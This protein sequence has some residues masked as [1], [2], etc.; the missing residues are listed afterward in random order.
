[1][2]DEFED[3]GDK[4]FRLLNVPDVDTLGLPTH[5]GRKPGGT[6]NTFVDQ[7][8]R[9]MANTEVA[10]WMQPSLRTEVER[11]GFDP[12]SLR[13]ETHPDFKGKP[14]A[15][16]FLGNYDPQTSLV[17]APIHMKLRPNRS[18]EELKDT[19]AHE[20][21]HRGT[22]KLRQQEIYPEKRHKVTHP[23]FIALVRTY[24]DDDMHA[25]AADLKRSGKRTQTDAF[26]HIL[27]VLED[28]KITSD[29]EIGK[30]I[31]TLRGDNKAID[32]IISKHYEAETKWQR[33]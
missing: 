2:A 28:R 33:P 22:H 27:D 6:H 26:R 11:Y 14:K 19:V 31:K 4:L 20:F 21:F 24:L 1:M 3:F 25:R 15:D 16:Y 13:M 30:E 17:Y 23:E 29:E 5:K 10:W 8:N 12:S 32:G 18:S 7:M 9:K